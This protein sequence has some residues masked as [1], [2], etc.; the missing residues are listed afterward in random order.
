MLIGITTITMIII[1]LLLF[2]IPKNNYGNSTII[3]V[4]LFQLLSLDIMCIVQ[5]RTYVL[6]NST[7]FAYTVRLV[8][9]KRELLYAHDFYIGRNNQ[10]STYIYPLNKTIYIQDA[11]IYRFRLCH[12]LQLA[13]C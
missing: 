6:D 4:K 1:N 11:I 7:F 8:R 12:L 5:Y 2:N 9:G 3:I 10:T 13:T